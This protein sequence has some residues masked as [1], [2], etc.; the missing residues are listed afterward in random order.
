MFC[1]QFISV[2]SHFGDY[3]SFRAWAVCSFAHDNNN[4]KKHRCVSLYAQNATLLN[5]LNVI[6][7][8]VNVCLQQCRRKGFQCAT[9]KT[10]ISLHI[11][12]ASKQIISALSRPS[13]IM[14]VNL[15]HKVHLSEWENGEA[16]EMLDRCHPS[17]ILI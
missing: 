1:V 17:W 3:L 7:E 8:M 16:N 9:I 12:L 11:H 5:S 15:W 6:W 2:A 13:Q 10:L 14:T 4:N